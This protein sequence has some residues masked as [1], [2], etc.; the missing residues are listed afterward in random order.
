[1]VTGFDGL[2]NVNDL[3]R[4]EFKTP[5]SSNKIA[6][7]LF[8][9]FWPGLGLPWPK[10]IVV[11]PRNQPLPKHLR[12]KRVNVRSTPATTLQKKTRQNNNVFGLGHHNSVKVYNNF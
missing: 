8:F 10:A 7:I 4:D 6:L 5:A 2:N 3:H 1:M 12:K 9:I 11:I